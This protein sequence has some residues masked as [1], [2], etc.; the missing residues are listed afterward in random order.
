M[1]QL[2]NHDDLIGLL[3][4][5]IGMRKLYFRDH[6]KV[7]ACAVKFVAHLQRLLD[8]SKKD[9]LFLGLAEGRLVL[10]GRFLVGP[11]ILGKGLVEL[12]QALRCGGILLRRAIDEEEVMSFLDLAATMKADSES[13]A[14]SRQMLA[15]RGIRN[16][17]LSPPYEDAGWFGQFLYDGQEAWGSDS[18]VEPDLDASVPVYQS[19]FDTVE[20]AHGGAR[21]GEA[22]DVAGALTA[23]ELL[24]DRAE[25]NFIDILRL[26]RYPDYDTFTV[27]HSVRVALLAALVGHREG[28]AREKLT[29]L[30]TAGLLHDVG[31]A[32]VPDE[33]LF[34]AGPLDEEERR[35]INR[36]P[37]LGARI[38]LENQDSSALAIGTAWGHHLRSDGGGYPARQPWTGPCRMTELIH[39]CDVFEAL[40]AIRPYKSGVSPLRA[41]EIMLADHGAFD[42]AAFAA[43]VRALGL[44]PPGHFVRLS[45]GETGLVLA[46]GPEVALPTIRI[47]HD[48]AGEPVPRGDQPT[49]DLASPAARGRRVVELLAEDQRAA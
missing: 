26:V 3:S 36:H 11:T 28:L 47:T 20:K 39:V 44:Y 24:L 6:A 49:L 9:S 34:K 42:P 27:G 25:G 29:D 30:V 8:Q 41:Y 45:S 37:S 33:I 48:T 19:L 32:F 5:G 2:L 46:A 21:G 1:S 40:T 35:V 4:S 13:L 38:L 7:R 23:G 15:S 16:L 43:F 12:L 31:K 18:T 14:G 10:A 22:I 17:E